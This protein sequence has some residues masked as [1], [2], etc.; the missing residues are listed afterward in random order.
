[1]VQRLFSSRTDAAGPRMRPPGISGPG[2]LQ[3][4]STARTAAPP[5][6]PRIEPRLAAIRQK[7]MAAGRG[8]SPRR[9]LALRQVRRID[10]ELA[11]H[12]QHAIRAGQ[13]QVGPPG[14]DR[15]LEGRWKTLAGGRKTGPAKQASCRLGGDQ[16]L[17]PGRRRQLLHGCFDPHCPSR[18]DR[19][20]MRSPSKQNRPRKGFPEHQGNVRRPPHLLVGD[21][22]GLDPERS[23]ASSSR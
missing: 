20:S 12:D 16:S 3:F 14:E 4:A 10:V 1:M 13:A 2:S 5:P 15:P 23:A 11:D 21:G 17:R 18:L 8:T 6:L 22:R 7:A 9:R 19:L